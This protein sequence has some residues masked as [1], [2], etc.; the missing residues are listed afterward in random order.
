MSNPMIERLTEQLG[1]QVSFESSFEWPCLFFACPSLDANHPITASRASAPF[2]TPQLDPTKY[3]LDAIV[4]VTNSFHFLPTP[5]LDL[6]QVLL[7]RPCGCCRHFLLFHSRVSSIPH[8]LTWSKCSLSALVVVSYSPYLGYFIHH[9]DT[10]H[11]FSSTAL[12]YTNTFS[13]TYI[14]R[15]SSFPRFS[16]VPRSTSPW[17]PD[18]CLQQGIYSCRSMAGSVQPSPL[19]R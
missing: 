1:R 12:A 8:N 11:W 9:F 16:L 5:Q 18:G 19:S 14:L 3:F 7:G 2:N 15:L 6:V 13:R 4:V 17:P 10:I